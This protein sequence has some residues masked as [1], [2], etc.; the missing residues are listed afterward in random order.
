M[1]MLKFLV[2][3]VF[4]CNSAFSTLFF[5]ELPENITNNILECLDHGSVNNYRVV[6]H[7]A[8]NH[9]IEYQER[10]ELVSSKLNENFQVMQTSK[11]ILDD[12]LKSKNESNVSISK[13]RLLNILDDCINSANY[14]REGYIYLKQKNLNI[15]KIENKL[16]LSAAK[17]TLSMI[18]EVFQ[19]I[20]KSFIFIES[21]NI[22]YNDD[23]Y[24]TKNTD[25]LGKLYELEKIVKSIPLQE[26]HQ[27]EYELSMLVVSKYAQQNKK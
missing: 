15:E 14:L 19:S 17:A 2:V 12:I 1:K 10:K 6:Y 18:L 25:I 9:F 13:K 8:N 16:T 3:G 27:V 11:T 24:D 5:D 21:S 26:I 4:F 23:V 7:Q 20:K 22:S